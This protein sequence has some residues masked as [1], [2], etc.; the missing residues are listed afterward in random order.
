MIASGWANNC[1]NELFTVGWV[2]CAVAEQ[3]QQY[4][5]FIPDRHPLRKKDNEILEQVY[6]L[7]AKLQEVPE[8]PKLLTKQIQ[9][10][11]SKVNKAVYQDNT[12]QLQALQITI[13]TLELN[14]IKLIK[15]RQD[16]DAAINALLSI[17]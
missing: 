7:V 12:A 5:G 8:A 1:G 13:N 15:S 4:G 10:V 11:K 17:I 9:A 2:T 16:E 3:T 6:A 14:V